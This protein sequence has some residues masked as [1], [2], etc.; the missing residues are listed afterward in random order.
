MVSR[1]AG[2]VV[3]ESGIGCPTKRKLDAARTVL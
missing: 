1:E 3:A 2:N